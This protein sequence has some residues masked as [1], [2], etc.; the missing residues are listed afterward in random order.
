MF[1][2][3]FYSIRTGLNVS[4][5]EKSRWSYPALESIYEL[6]FMTTIRMDGNFL[7]SYFTSFPNGPQPSLFQPFG[8]KGFIFNSKTKK[9]N[10]TD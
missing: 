4:K 10:F 2:T 5:L 6:N 7:K 9:T 3:V 8:Q 1:R